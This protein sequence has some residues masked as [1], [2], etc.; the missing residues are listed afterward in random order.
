VGVAT[1]DRSYL[2]PIYL[3]APTPTHRYNHG[4]DRGWNRLRVEAA[5]M[6]GDECALLPTSYPTLFESRN[7]QR[8]RYGGFGPCTRKGACDTCPIYRFTI[9]GE[10]RTLRSFTPRVL[11]RIHERHGP[12]VMN[13]PEDGWGSYGYYWTWAELAHLEGWDLGRS[14]NDEHSAG[15]WLIATT[16]LPGG[17]YGD[18]NGKPFRCENP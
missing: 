17:I 3:P 5:F 6:S 8:A 14:H 2:M 7:T 12:M 13:K 9:E 11:V 18:P 10:K 16:R 4:R 1:S 15:F